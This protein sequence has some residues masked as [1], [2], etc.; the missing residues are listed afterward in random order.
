MMQEA[1]ER[2]QRK[3]LIVDDDPDILNL[4]GMRLKA[5]GYEIASAENGKEALAQISINRPALV[6]S[7]LRMPEMD[8]FD[9]FDAIHQN[10][11][12]LPVIMLTAHGSIPDA[13]NATQRGV[14]GHLGGPHAEH[15]HHIRL[16]VLGD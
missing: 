7:D 12:T 11:S 4:L 1:L 5:A 16:Q 8:G 6:I 2:A 15:L 3:I 13:V 9:L 14:F 10:D